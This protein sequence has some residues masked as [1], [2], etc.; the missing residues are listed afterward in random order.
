MVASWSGLTYVGARE[1]AT[2]NVDHRRPQRN[3]D[4]RRAVRGLH[5][6]ERFCRGWCR[7]VSRYKVIAG[8]A[9]HHVEGVTAAPGAGLA[10]GHT[11]CDF[12][13]RR[14][15]DTRRREWARRTARA[16][17]LYIDR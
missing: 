16:L 9:T 17:S 7:N 6:E 8:A 4:G 14:A 1:L 5:V 13:E 3:P 2:T 12:D 10:P 11:L 15:H